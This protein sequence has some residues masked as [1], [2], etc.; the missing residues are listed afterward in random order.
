M[1][2]LFHKYT[3]KL[4]E[5]KQFIL[6]I[7]VLGF[8]YKVFLDGSWSVLDGDILF[9]NGSI[10]VSKIGNK[11]IECRADGEITRIDT[12]KQSLSYAAERQFKVEA[13]SV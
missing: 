3:N 4:D 1:T 13:Y 7:E 9:A 6:A 8:K 10:E 11:I 12:T 2:K 5:V